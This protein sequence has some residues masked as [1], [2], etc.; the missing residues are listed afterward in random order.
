MLETMKKGAA[1]KPDLQPLSVL[2]MVVDEDVRIL[3]LN[4]ASH[5]FPGSERGQLLGRPGGEAFQCA[6]FQEDPAGCGHGRFCQLCPIRGA[7]AAAHKEQRVVRRRT[8]AEMGEG[9]EARE[10]HLLVT[11]TPLPSAGSA[12]ILLALED[13]SAL[14][15]L[16]KFSPICACCARIHPDEEYWRQVELHFREHFDLDLSHGVCPACQEQL[17]GTLLDRQAPED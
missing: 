17:Y 7:V 5:G 9:A 10:V 11:A 15:A 3:E 4:G 8:K 12:R 13:I 1:G 16:Q 2:I 6:H 14:V